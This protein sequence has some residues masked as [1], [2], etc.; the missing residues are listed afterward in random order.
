MAR[1]VDQRRRAGRLG[2]C[3]EAFGLLDLT[4]VSNQGVVFGQRERDEQRGD[5]VAERE[6]FAGRSD[7]DGDHR[8]QALWRQGL[9]TTAQ[10]FTQ[11]A[12]G[13]CEDDVV[14]RPPEALL[15]LLQLGER[16][17]KG[18]EPSPGADRFVQ[19]RLRGRDHLLGDQ[20]LHQRLRARK[21][22]G[23]RFRVA[24]RRLHRAD[25]APDRGAGG[26]ERR[27]PRRSTRRS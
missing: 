23:G 14:H 12:R 8:P 6:P 9:L 22:L 26:V 27:A 13:C 21:S 10:Q 18:G 15:Y 3:F 11:A 19:A 20:E 1:E 2:A 5:P 25:R 7:A 4:A 24:Y 17:S 16:D